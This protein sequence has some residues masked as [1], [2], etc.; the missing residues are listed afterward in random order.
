MLP[1]LV[2]CFWQHIIKLLFIFILVQLLIE[3]IQNSSTLIE[4]N[5]I[6][7]CSDY[8]SKLISTCSCLADQIS[9]FIVFL[10]TRDLAIQDKVV[11]NEL[12]SS[13]N[14][15]HL[16]TDNQRQCN[17]GLC[18]HFLSINWNFNYTLNRWVTTV[19]VA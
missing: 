19:L 18:K 16:A 17:T 7:K 3:I 14:F 2:R 5:Y 15:S 4:L 10:M 13:F 11:K 9:A 12:I 8:E 1:N 6:N